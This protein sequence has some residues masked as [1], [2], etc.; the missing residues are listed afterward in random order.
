MRYQTNAFALGSIAVTG[1]IAV[2]PYALLPTAGTAVWPAYLCAFTACV[3]ATGPY[4][5][6]LGGRAVSTYTALFSLAVNAVLLIILFA[7]IYGAY[8]LATYPSPDTQTT[9]YFSTVTWTTLGYGDFSAIGEL[10]LL[11]AGQA[12]IGYIFLGLIVGLLIEVANDTRAR[13][14]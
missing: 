1:T 13:R 7:G 10:R 14:D 11:A 6:H 9:I 3:S 12:V 5:A 4:I 2:L 8:G